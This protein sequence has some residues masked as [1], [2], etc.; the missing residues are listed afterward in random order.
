[1]DREWV[2]LKEV[3]ARR[4]KEIVSKEVMALLDK[5]IDTSSSGLSTKPFD[6]VVDALKLLSTKNVQLD[7]GWTDEKVK[8][9]RFLFDG[10]PLV[11]VF[12]NGI[13]LVDINSKMEKTRRN[14]HFNL[15]LTKKISSHKIRGGR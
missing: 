6:P 5:K 9:W 4:R 14:Y 1:V 15:P 8:F 10:D 7:V 12:E 13:V 2:T 3:E 11:C